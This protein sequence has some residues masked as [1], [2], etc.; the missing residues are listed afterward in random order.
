MGEQH[1]REP[2]YQHGVDL[3]KRQ[4]PFVL[5][6]VANQVWHDDPRRLLFFLSRYKFVSKMFSG[7]NRVLEIGCGDGFG[8]RVVLQ[9]VS[10]LTA[11]DF[12][13]LFVEDAKAHI[14]P[15][16]PFEC[17]VHDMLEGPVPGSFDGVYALD[18]IEHIPV[19][20]ERRFI[21]N[22]VASLAEHG[23]MI[24]GSPSL[25]S[26]AYASPQSKA[27]HVNCKS[28]P[29]LKKLLRDFFHLVFVFSMNDE[30]VHTGFHPMAHYLLALC[31]DK[32]R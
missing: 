21:G 22:A 1:T 9:E 23:T 5:P 25:E 13:P 15:R 11:V 27:G 7:M 10:H 32:I 2:Q 20:H 28:G 3:Y 31:C 18:V 30:V 6:L 16:W 4:A 19:E 17:F 26:V 12:D 24:L 29:M 8:G 14:D